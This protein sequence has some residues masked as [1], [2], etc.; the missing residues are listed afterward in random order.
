MAPV[1]V[2]HEYAI[3]LPYQPREVRGNSPI[4]PVTD[5]I[6]EADWG[7]TAYL[8]GTGSYNASTCTAI[9]RERGP[10]ARLKLECWKQRTGWAPVPTIALGARAASPPQTGMLE[11]ADRLGARPDNSPGCAGRQPASNWN[12]GN[13][14]QVGH[15]SLHVRDERHR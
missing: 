10:P 2:S 12:A 14:G 6:D 1:P 4:L 13:S 7:M 5:M 11:T 9:A 8:L 15:P 3:A